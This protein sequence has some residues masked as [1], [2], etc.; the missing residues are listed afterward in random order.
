MPTLSAVTVPVSGWA[1][2]PTVSSTIEGLAADAAA[3]RA[4]DTTAPAKVGQGHVPPRI[5]IGGCGLRRVP[6]VGLAQSGKRGRQSEAGSVLASKRV[7]AQIRV[8]DR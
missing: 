5:Q 1:S 8:P 7:I 3:L 2:D 4:I 6:A